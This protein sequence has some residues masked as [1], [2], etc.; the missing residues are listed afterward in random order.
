VAQVIQYTPSADWFGADSFTIQA[1]DL[2][3]NTDL[4]QVDVTVNPVNDPP[5]LAQPADLARAARDGLVTVPL[6][7]ISGGP[8]NEPQAVTLSVVT[9]RPDLLQGLAV[10]YPG[11]GATGSLSF[12]LQDGT[13]TA[14][15]TV[16][17]ND[18][19]QTTQRV[20]HV[21]VGKAWR[22]LYFPQT[23]RP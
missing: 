19:E 9:D 21:T 20:F 12:T 4:L 7:G 18:G 16:T 23:F 22:K 2:S 14:A 13:G 3:G 15:V 10:S 5:G 17:V 6:T 11:A 1:R 8:S